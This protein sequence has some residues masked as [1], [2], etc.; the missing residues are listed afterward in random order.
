MREHLGHMSKARWNFSP[1]YGVLEERLSRQVKQHRDLAA[2]GLQG[3]G[4]VYC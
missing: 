1:E 4:D 3:G 2:R